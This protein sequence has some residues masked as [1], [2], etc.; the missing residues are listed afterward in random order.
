MTE[1]EIFVHLL[2]QW[3]ET[4]DVQ[5]SNALYYINRSHWWQGYDVLATY[6][7]LEAKI[8]IEAFGEF[9]GELRDIIAKF[10]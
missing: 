7:A 3:L 8:R 10:G 2:L 5:I 1:K 6:K 9:A 4:K